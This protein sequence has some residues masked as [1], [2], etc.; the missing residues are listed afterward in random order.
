MQNNSDSKENPVPP[1]VQAVT[2][3]SKNQSDSLVLGVHEDEQLLKN[4]HRE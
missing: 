1:G 2:G 4:H 3:E